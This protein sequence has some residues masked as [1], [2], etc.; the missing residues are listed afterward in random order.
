ML[1]ES[2]ISRKS[3]DNGREKVYGNSNHETVQ[4]AEPRVRPQRKF[5]YAVTVETQHFDR[6]QWR[7]VWWNAQAPSI[8]SVGGWACCDSWAWLLSPGVSRRGNCSYIGEAFSDCS[9]RFGLWLVCADAPLWQNRERKVWI[10]IK[11]VYD[12]RKCTANLVVAYHC[13][14]SN[15][16]ITKLHEELTIRVDEFTDW[17]KFAAV[18]AVE[19]EGIMPYVTLLGRERYVSGY[20]LV[21]IETYIS[22][23][24]KK[25]WKY[26]F[27]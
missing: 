15:A 20:V 26:I 19:N 25:T 24:V 9:I 2:I 3:C 13:I 22:F 6:Q 18:G 4:N 14:Y 16:L 7:E 17:V 1:T 23:Y 21:P 8:C 12:N 5:L 27:L 10:I 11:E